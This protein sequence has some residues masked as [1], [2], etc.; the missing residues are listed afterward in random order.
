M[1]RR[2]RG[3]VI[4]AVVVAGALA[5][6]GGFAYA[7]VSGDATIKACAKTDNG[8]LR[9]DPG[10]GCL[11]SEQALQWN[12]TGPQGLQGLPGPQGPAGVTH[13]QERFFARSL[14]NVGTWLPI[15]SGTWPDVR[16]FLTHV[17]TMHVDK[18]NYAVTGEIVAENDGGHGVVVC[19]L[20][21]S[22]VGF[23]VA[24]SAV[25]DAPGF[26]LQQTFELQSIFPLDEA[27]DLELSCF[28]APPNEPAGNPRI[29]LADV[30]ATKI[31]TVAV[32][33]EP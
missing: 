26:A 21:N 20:G 8:Q 7:Q 32:S 18:G 16:P 10:S 12:Q 15:V 6:A 25:G 17:L 1:N 14:A 31:D 30:V 5:A 33:Q 11:P 22:T 24:Q 28:N 23:A 2:I 27:G 13:A 4:L 29:G 3:S 19:L 9:L